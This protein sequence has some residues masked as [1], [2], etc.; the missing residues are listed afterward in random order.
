MSKRLHGNKKL[1]RSLLA[2]AIATT[3]ASAVAVPAI[4]WAQTADATLRGK[5]AANSEVTAKNVATGVSRHTT[6]DAEGIY[7]LVGLPPGTYHVDAGPGT[8]TVVT[9]TVASTATL[10]LEPGAAVVIPQGTLEEIT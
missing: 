5:S 6:A 8:E 1:Y 3:L 10:D 9:L 7:T 2:T 4:S